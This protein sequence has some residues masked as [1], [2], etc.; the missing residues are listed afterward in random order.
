MHKVR[1]FVLDCLNVD[2]KREERRVELKV[3]APLK[4]WE[5]Q[6]LEVDWGTIP[7]LGK[8]FLKQPGAEK[9]LLWLGLRPEFEVTEKELPDGHLEVVSAVKILS[10]RTR[11]KMFDG[12]ACSCSTMESNFRF[13]FVAIEENETPPTR[14]EA[15]ELTRK[16]LG[17][18]KKARRWVN[19]RQTEPEWIWHRRYDNPNI[20]D[21]RNKVRQMAQKRAL[22]KCVKNMGAMSELFAADPSEWDMTEEQDEGNPYREKDYTPEGNRIVD[23]AGFS[24]SGKAVTREAQ[25]AQTQAVGQAK[26]ETL[27]ETIA[28]RQKEAGNGSQA[29]PPA[30]FAV[31][32]KVWLYE[33]PGDTMDVWVTGWLSDVEVCKFLRDTLAKQRPSKNNKA[34][35]VIDGQYVV[36]FRKLCRKLNLELTDAHN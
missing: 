33:M 10:K 28:E 31:D 18:W 8:P 22:V 6:E 21:E 20:N 5:I 34:G 4:P 23:S 11:E 1:R 35:W 17:K 27:K 14:D 3:R 12:P 25:H 15:E 19:G 7:G 32:R 29:Q 24:P 16:G 30:K 9:F 26:A 2:L 13:R 36:D